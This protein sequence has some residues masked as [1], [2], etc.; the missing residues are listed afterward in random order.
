MTLVE[1]QCSNVRM[2]KLVPSFPPLGEERWEDYSLVPDGL[3]SG[4]LRRNRSC[5]SALAPG[6]VRMEV[7]HSFDLR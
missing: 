6:C 3:L 2:E 1:P 7:G 5:M 4:L